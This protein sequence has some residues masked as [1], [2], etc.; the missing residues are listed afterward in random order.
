[1]TIIA[2]DWY[3]FVPRAFITWLS[4]G[5]TIRI[6]KMIKKDDGTF[7]FKAAS[8][9]FP[10]KHKGIV[11]NIGIAETGQWSLVIKCIWAVLNVM[12]IGLSS[13]F[14]FVF[15]QIYNVC[16]CGHHHCDLGSEGRG[17]SY[18]QH[19]S[20][21]QLLCCCVTMWKVSSIQAAPL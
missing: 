7:S 8:E 3:V 1:M 10:Q 13:N 11:M 5:E 2:A 9:D 6:Y 4:T 19:E 21:D 18:Y 12:N 15:R 14:I 17:F 16:L 20:D